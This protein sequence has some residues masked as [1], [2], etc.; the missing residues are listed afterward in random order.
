MDG[1]ARIG[2]AEAE[3]QRAGG[4]LQVDD[5]GVGIRGL[6]RLD[7]L[8]ERLARRRDLPPAIERGDDV[9][10]RHLLAVVELDAAAER[11]GVAP[12]P[13]A[14]GMALGEERDRAVGLVVRVER[15]V[16]VPGD[17]LGDHR[18]RRVQVERGRLPDHGHLQHAPRPRLLLRHDGHGGESEPSEGEQGDECARLGLHEMR[19]PDAPARGGLAP[20]QRRGDRY[21]G[22][23]LAR[24]RQR[25]NRRTRRLPAATFTRRSRRSID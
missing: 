10:G 13:V 19:L 21:G 5:D 8:P 20:R 12:S 4:L 18:G 11:D 6:D 23:S 3:E 7:V 1:R 22:Q 24:G 16:D 15:L 14:H 9:G 25:V 2:P 17:L